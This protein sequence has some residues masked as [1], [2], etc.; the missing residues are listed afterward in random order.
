MQLEPIIKQYQACLPMLT[1]DFSN[2]LSIS[3]ISNTSQVATVETTTD[4][5]LS[6]NDFVTM[7]N[8]Y[9]P[10][11][12][13]TANES[14]TEINF[15]TVTPHD[16]SKSDRAPADQNQ[17]VRITSDS[18]PF[19]EL[20]LLKSVGN[21][22]RFIVERTTQPALPVGET[23]SLQEQAVIGFNGLK[24]VI[25]VPTSTSFTYNMD[26]DFPSPNYV[27]GAFVSV[28]QRISGGIDI[29][30][31]QASY[32]KQLNEQLWLFVTPIQSAANKDRRT[33]LDSQSTQSQQGDFRQR[34][35][36]GFETYV[37]VPNKGEIVTKTNARFAYDVAQDLRPSIFKC[38][39]G[40]NFDS[41][42]ACQGQEVITY[43]GDG[44]FLYNGTY[45][46]H[47]FSF[48]LVLDITPD[49]TARDEFTRA[50]RTIMVTHK[51]QFSD[52]TTYTSQ[53]DLDEQ[54][55]TS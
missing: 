43:N 25:S 34:V 8:V 16:L 7:G 3:S 14:A 50:F 40:L 18:S 44:P 42:L 31:I 26:F 22:R 36:D 6:V 19:D 30:L 39:L 54:P 53:I 17:M 29:D 5:G 35:I 46:I 55:E 10:V 15:L 41:G 27:V 13:D 4:H 24:Q 37:F 1:D 45:Y 38:V 28:G 11:I 52:I 49:D 9:S 21:R 48:Q 12:I 47:R 51:N 33:P 32:T 23:L 20:Y 2:K